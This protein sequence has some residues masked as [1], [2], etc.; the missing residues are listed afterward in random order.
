MYKNKIFLH[1]SY[2]GTTGY[3][4]HT[5]DFVRHLSDLTDI[6]VRNFTV[7]KTWS[8]MSDNPHDNESYFNEIDKKVLY[9][10]ILTTPNGRENFKMYKDKSKDFKPD[11][12]VVL[13][14]TNHYIF[15]D[16]YDGPRIAYNVWESTLQPEHFFKRLSYFD[17]FWVPSKWQKECTVKQGEA[18]KKGE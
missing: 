10:Q 6:K 3:N 7:G 1:G 12:H 2:I 9:E 18:L 13:C 14:E 15:Y 16:N 11:V 5:R 17:E 8:G 4:Q